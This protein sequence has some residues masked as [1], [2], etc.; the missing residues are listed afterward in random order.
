MGWNGAGAIFDPVADALIE[1]NV[2]PEVKRK[3]LATLI[4][5]LRDGDW[6]TLDE[7]AD[8]FADDPIIVSLFAE[9]GVTLPCD[10]TDGPPGTQACERRL[11][12]DGD[13][14]DANDK[15]W[16]KKAQGN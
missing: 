14:V 11:F 7:S 1:S 6:D 4:R 10:A 2:A 3:V 5:V 13:H 8:A 15:S 9:N 16:W 12:H